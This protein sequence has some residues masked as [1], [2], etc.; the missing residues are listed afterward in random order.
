M[1]IGLTKMDISSSGSIFSS[2]FFAWIVVLRRKVISVQ[3]KPAKAIQLQCESVYL[4]VFWHS[5]QHWNRTKQRIYTK[6]TDDIT[7]SD[8]TPQQQSASVS[9]ISIKVVL[10]YPTSIVII[11]NTCYS[12]A[13]I[14]RDPRRHNLWR[15]YIRTADNKCLNHVAWLQPGQCYVLL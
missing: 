7:T 13:P 1:N 8:I 6:A 4:E 14:H 3:V 9:I 15:R 5:F 2:L 12:E 11:T 10:L